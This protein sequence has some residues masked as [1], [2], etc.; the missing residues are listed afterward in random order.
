MFYAGPIIQKKLLR[1]YTHTG[2]NMENIIGKDKSGWEVRSHF[3]IMWNACKKRMLS[4][5]AII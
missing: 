4:L 3:R 5:C 1:N 2:I